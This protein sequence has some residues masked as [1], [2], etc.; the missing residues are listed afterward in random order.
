M[1]HKAEFE[2]K[3]N[4]SLKCQDCVLKSFFSDQDAQGLVE[5]ALILGLVAIICIASISSVGSTIYSLFFTN[6]KGA[7]TTTT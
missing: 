7:L 6:V 3:T 1:N 4:D 5:Y 2:I